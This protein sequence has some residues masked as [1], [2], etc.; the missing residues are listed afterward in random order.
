MNDKDKIETPMSTWVQRLAI[1]GGTGS[2]VFHA[3]GVLTVLLAVAV[4]LFLVVEIINKKNKGMMLIPLSLGFLGFV[5]KAVGG[6]W[7]RVDFQER[8][9]ILLGIALLM[10]VFLVVRG[11]RLLRKGIILFNRLP[12]KRRLVF[13][14][15]FTELAFI[16]ASVVMIGQGTQWGGDEPHYLVIAH[17]IARDL[18]LNVFNQYA[19]DEYLEFSEI[20][21]SHHARVG[22][23]FKVWYSYGH[24]PGLSLTLAPFFLV[25]IP[26]PLLYYLVRG[27]LGLFGA[28]LAVLVYLMALKL[29]KNKSLAL[30]I[31]TVF[32]FTAPVFFYSVHVFAELQVSLLILSSLYLVLFAEKKTG[33]RFLLAGLLLGIT[34][35]WGLKYTIFIFMLSGGFFFYWLIKKREP[36]KAIMF[37]IFPIVVQGLFLGYLHMAYGS[38]D[39]MNIYNGLMTLEQQ[40][41]YRQGMEAIPLQKRAETLLGIFFD[42]R[43]GLLLYNPFYLLALPGVILALKRYR[44]YWPHIAIALSGAAFVFFIGYSTVRAGYCPQA[45]YLAPVSWIMMMLA[46][47]YY[48]ETRN[49]RLKRLML[50]IP[51]YAI[52]VT[53]YQVLEP[54]TLY[55]SATHTNINRPALMFLQW[56]NIHLDIS[57]ILPSWVKVPGNFQ[58]LPNLISLVLVALFTA[59]ALK[60]TKREK[61]TRPQKKREVFYPPMAIVLSALAAI[62]IMF[63]RI[64]LYNPILL[65][66]DG[67]IPCTIY[68]ES[69]Y[70]TRTKERTF[71]W[72]KEKRY[73]YTVSTLTPAPFFVMEWEN[74]GKEDYEISLKQ[75]DHECQ[76]VVVK[77]GAVKKL[78]IE[79][80]VYKRFKKRYFFRFHL[81]VPT[82]SPGEPMIY[83]RLYPVK[84]R[85]SS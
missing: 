51:L 66:K 47:I 24:L 40:E 10:V 11:Y 23:G 4:L 25:K 70:P 35:F 74:Q 68:G 44:Q 63:P 22:K 28:A 9:Y 61:I 60:K 38:F 71:A 54:F 5:M 82:V 64:P 6:Y 73:S 46:I 30:F 29:W 39:P 42:Q 21:L 59:W 49:Y 56:S 45:R 58:Y 1:M 15:L 14:F 16:S 2:F 81:D 8:V 18:D 65:A 19:R 76:T 31:T 78:V 55:E 41:Q 36:K 79:N 50:Y 12:L 52:F 7:D 72:K 48:R 77:G 37:I 34:V 53:I 69:D 85:G 75:F 13:I 84:T 62:L 26:L 57:K 3:P 32:S 83:Y 43:D 27:Y 33:W 67:A 80:P 17:S 20:H